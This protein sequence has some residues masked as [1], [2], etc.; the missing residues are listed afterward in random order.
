MKLL[1]NDLT[2]SLIV[3]YFTGDDHCLVSVM[4]F[5]ILVVWTQCLGKGLVIALEKCPRSKNDS[6]LAP[7]PF[8]L[9]VRGDYRGDF[10]KGEFVSE[11]ATL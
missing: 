3:S 2:L 9:L 8:L 6:Q 11:W 1:D 7:P 4:N 10:E 5:V